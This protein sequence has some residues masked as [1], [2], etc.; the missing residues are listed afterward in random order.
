MNLNR[1]QLLNWSGQSLAAIALDAMLSCESP[2]GQ[3]PSKPHQQPRAKSVIWLMMRGGVSH[4]EGF[5]PKPAL[6]KY[7]GKTLNETP[8]HSAVVDSPH[9]RNVREQVANNVIKTDQAKIFPLQT[10]YRKCGESGI[11]V[12]DWWPETR[13]LVDEIS[14]VRSMWTTDNNHG[15]QLQCLTARQLLNACCPTIGAWIHYG[16][17]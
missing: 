14:V 13:K 1:R 4:H 11:E 6:N 3:T 2:A 9:Y 5:D 10:G 15:A 16:L 8:Y 7:A 12:S 17:G